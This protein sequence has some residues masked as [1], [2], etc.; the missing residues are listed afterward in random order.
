[1]SQASASAHMINRLIATYDNLTLEYVPPT[2]QPGE[3]EHVL[4]MQDETVFHSNEYQRRSWLA[5]DQQPIWKKG[6]GQ[7]IHVSDFISE[8]IGWIRLTPE[9]ISDQ[10]QLLEKLRLSVFE[11]QI[12]IYPGKNPKGLWW[13]LKQLI[14]QI[15]ITILSFDA[16]HPNCIRIFVFDQSSAQEGFSEDA[17][18]V[19]QMNVYWW[20]A[21]VT[22]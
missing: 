14:E 2:L 1:M 20:V 7:A 16:T 5:Q 10:L 9:Q 17:L 4:I 22:L 8:A 12:I 6:R 3:R 21:E 15:K 18:N 19:N 13:N 11:A